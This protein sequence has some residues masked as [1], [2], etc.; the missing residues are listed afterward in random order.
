M[1]QTNFDKAITRE[2]PTEEMMATFRVEG[3]KFSAEFNGKT[4]KADYNN[5]ILGISCKIDIAKLM[6]TLNKKGV[7]KCSKKPVTT[8]NLN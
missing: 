7:E 2:L 3:K 5:D 1:E 6:E 4:L 8:E